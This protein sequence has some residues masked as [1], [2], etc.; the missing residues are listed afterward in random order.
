MKGK[1]FE[2]RMP[3]LLLLTATVAGGWSGAASGAVVRFATGFGNVDVRL[4]EQATPASVSNFLSYVTR[5]DWQNVLIHR[6]VPGFIIQGG[7]YRF[8][9]SS[10]IE[11]ANFP[12]V[13]QQAVVTNEPGISNLRGTIAY[14]KLGGFP[15]SATREWFFN[16][17]NNT[18]GP[19]NLDT[20]NGG[21]TVFGR[22]L[23]AGMNVVDAIA[24]VPRFEFF[25]PWDEA[26][27]RNYTIANYTNYVPVGAANVVN[28]SISVLNV[29]N[30]DYNFDG[31]VNQADVCVW[32]ATLGSTTQAEADG[33]GDG[34]VNQAD[35]NVWAANAQPAALALVTGIKF[36]QTTR[37]P[38]GAF[39]VAFTNAPGLCLSLA[40]TTNSA[41]PLSQW[42][43]LGSVPEI[44]PGQYQFTDVQATNLTR[45]F[46]RVTQP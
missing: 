40:T 19:G 33:N 13:P 17:A 5:G 35:F 1:F 23:G 34:I 45:R 43:A 30:G 42:T 2:T 18:N 7:R 38:N 9:G 44:A 25:P 6:S 10:Q 15:N 28:L 12:Q 21:F 27:M 3:A 4:Y 14:A 24:A 29:P 37:L 32:R 8:D 39:R 26:P 22:V 31:L 11:P 41:A 46:Y 16:L 36:T 20:Q